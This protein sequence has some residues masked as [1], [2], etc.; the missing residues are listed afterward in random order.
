MTRDRVLDDLAVSE[1]T[2]AE[3]ISHL[4]ETF[5]RAAR[6]YPDLLGSYLLRLQGRDLIEQQAIMRQALRETFRA[7]HPNPYLK[8]D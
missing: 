5:D 4:M 1:W 8:P 6:T 2:D 7:R 3:G